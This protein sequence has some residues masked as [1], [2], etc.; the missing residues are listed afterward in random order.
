[1]SLT[2]HASYTDRHNNGYDPVTFQ[3]VSEKSK[4]NFGLSTRAAVSRAVTL[5]GRI[6]RTW[7]GENPEPDK[8]DAFN[9][10]LLGTGVPPIDGRGWQVAIGAS[11]G[12]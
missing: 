4:W 8:I 5:T 11:F 1:M 3:F 6:E 7:T 10:V 2:G 12:F 9:N